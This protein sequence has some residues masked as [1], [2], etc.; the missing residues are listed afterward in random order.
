MSFALRLELF[1]SLLN[2]CVGVDLR[3]SQQQLDRFLSMFN[4]SNEGLWIMDET[5][6]T[7]FY[8]RTFYDQFELPASDATFDD[9]VALV[10]PDDRLMF[11]DK[12]DRHIEQHNHGVHIKNEYR[13]RKKDG[14][15]CW[16]EANGVTDYDGENYMAGSHKDISH[17]RKILSAVKRLAFFDKV[18]GL[19]N[20][21]Q[22]N[23]DYASLDDNENKTLVFIHLASI[24][25]HFSLYGAE[26]VERLIKKFIRCFSVF[27][28]YPAKPYRTATDIFLVLL[29]VSV[30][31]SELKTMFASFLERC[32][33]ITGDERQSYGVD[34]FLGAVQFTGLDKSAGEMVQWAS[35]TCEYAMHHES[36]KWA[37]CNLQ[38]QKK[39]ERFFYIESQLQQAIEAQ[40]ISI[41]LQ[42]IFDVRKKTLNTFEALARWEISELGPIYPDEFI[43]AAERKGLI[44][45]LGEYVFK[46]ACTFI[47]AY[48]EKWQTNV[49]VNV[50]VSGLQLFDGHFPERIIN[51]LETLEIPPQWIVLELT[52][53]VLLD[54][55][56]H[57]IEQLKKLKDYGFKLSMD[58]F[59]TGYSSI[60]GFFQLPFKQIKL[61]KEL[62]DEAMRTKEVFSYMDFVTQLCIDNGVEVIVEGIED[63]EMLEKF[64][65]IGVNFFQ[66][67]FLSRPLRTDDAFSMNQCT[68]DD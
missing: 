30:T 61:D 37:I 59:G 38:L 48:N 53:S 52:E 66:G 20:T 56:H 15:F 10:H 11:T 13:V 34:V 68:L 47:R 51:I 65:A 49:R 62:A 67:F 60:M 46:Q 19:P 9:W 21:E 42:P 26:V 17:Q 2:L 1:F 54:H 32:R 63:R 14:S 23:I 7:S 44:S 8:N 55:K 12:V 45:L 41:Y 57:A 31:E 40:E 3:L 58:D 43:P 4:S 25:S 33:N 50:N 35:K 6:K 27:N 28:K 16:I 64:D 39:I 5:G 29:P 18:T 22:F 36:S 24:K